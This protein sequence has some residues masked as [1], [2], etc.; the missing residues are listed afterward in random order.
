MAKCTDYTESR[1]TAVITGMVVHPLVL[2]QL[3][4]QW[5]KEVRFGSP[6]YDIAAEI[7]VDYFRQY[8]KAPGSAFESLIWAWGEKNPHREADFRML[9]DVFR[10]VEA[11]GDYERQ[12]NELN[13]QFVLGLAGEMF[14]KLALRR[15]LDKAEADWSAGNVGKVL[16]RITE[17][18]AVE[19]GTESNGRLLTDPAE[20]DY[21]FAESPASLL[22]Y[23]GALGEFFGDTLARDSLMAF[24]APEKIGKSFMLMDVAFRAVSQRKKTAFFGTGDMSK[25]QIYWRLLNRLAKHPYRS[26]THKW[27]CTIL[28]PLTVEPPA[29]KGEPA[30]VTHKQM[31]FDAPLAKQQAQEALDHFRRTKIKS[32]DDYLYVRAY[33]AHTINVQGIRSVLQRWDQEGFTADVVVIDYADIMAPPAGTGRFD[34][35]DQVNRTWLQLRSLSTERSCLVVTATQANAKSY[36]QKGLL[37]RWH[38]SEDKRKLANVTAVAGINVSDDEKD[39]GLMQLNWVALREG[40]FS[41]RKS[42]HCAGCLALS[43]PAILSCK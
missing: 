15:F 19:L 28:Y 9:E 6:G 22:K 14:N 12:A 7:C 35:R 33:P 36:G 43:M 39:L 38:F 40:E 4:P 29:G 31:T 11:G 32:W 10:L 23:P 2:G 26:P 1:A 21:A 18:R 17:F 42:V 16:Q 24:M 27:P 5:D 30:V 8:G 34:A 3:V 25:R 37:Q 20:L 13:P 41:S